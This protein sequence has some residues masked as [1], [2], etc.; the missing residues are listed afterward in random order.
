M[1]RH[2][3]KLLVGL[4]VLKAVIALIATGG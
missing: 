2:A 3:P 4:L 1:A